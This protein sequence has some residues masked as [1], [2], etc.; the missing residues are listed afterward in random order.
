MCYKHAWNTKPKYIVPGHMGDINNLYNNK[1]FALS[2]IQA[3]YSHVAVLNAF[4]ECMVHLCI[5]GILK[6]PTSQSIIFDLTTYLKA[7][8]VPAISHT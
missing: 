8:W 6:S 5:K 4:P 2:N 1:L 7:A 3:K